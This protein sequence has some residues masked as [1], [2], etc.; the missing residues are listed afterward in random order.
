MC[1]GREAK[2]RQCER[3]EEERQCAGREERAV[4]RQAEAGAGSEA[5]GVAAVQVR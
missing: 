2:K 3:Q 1:A 5:E 4:V